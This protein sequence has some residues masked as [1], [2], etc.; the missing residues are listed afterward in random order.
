MYSFRTYLNNKLFNEAAAN[1]EV[2][3]RYAKSIKD[4]PNLDDLKTLFNL[5]KKNWTTDEQYGLWAD[6]LPSIKD[7][8]NKLP[9]N[10]QLEAE[11]MLN[12]FHA[13]DSELRH[14]MLK[15][16]HFKFKDFYEFENFIIKQIESDYPSN[17]VKIAMNP[18]NIHYWDMLDVQLKKDLL[19][20]VKEERERSKNRPTFGNTIRDAIRR[21]REEGANEEGLF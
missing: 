17:G 5:I 18:D 4:N 12:S 14:K 19:D 1:P 8:I 21:S 15:S 9:E 13:S 16:G 20:A 3:F 6:M 11:Q 2:I 7:I 10:E